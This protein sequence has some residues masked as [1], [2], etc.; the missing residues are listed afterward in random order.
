MRNTLH[1][2][3]QSQSRAQ[4]AADP[5]IRESPELAYQHKY[6]GKQHEGTPY[7]I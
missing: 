1:N 3:R 4:N 5:N 7:P 2:E 6:R